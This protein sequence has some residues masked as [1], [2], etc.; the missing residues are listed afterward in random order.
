[1][2]PYLWESIYDTSALLLERIIVPLTSVFS[3][4]KI[5][6]GVL[7]RGGWFHAVKVA[8]KIERLPQVKPMQND[9]T[10]VISNDYEVFGPYLKT[11]S[12]NMFSKSGK[13]NA[14]QLPS[15]GIKVVFNI[16]TPI[17]N[18]NDEWSSPISKISNQ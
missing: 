3:K 6:V 5:G 10:S 15:D 13:I 4:Q 12:K 14:G 8:L 7:E 11:V 9:H 18:S 1:M 16:A 2:D 17:K